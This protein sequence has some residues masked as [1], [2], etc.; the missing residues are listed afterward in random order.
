[1]DEPGLE[2]EL[3][4]SGEIGHGQPSPGDGP[5]TDRAGRKRT[6]RQVPPAF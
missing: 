1:M 4:G 5:G 6:V 2:L 3:L